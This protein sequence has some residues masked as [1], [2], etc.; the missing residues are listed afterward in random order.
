[1]STLHVSPGSATVSMGKFL[2]SLD[3]YIVYKNFSTLE[4][5]LYSR[6]CARPLPLRCLRIPAE[7]DNCRLFHRELVKIWQAKI[8]RHIISGKG[9]ALSKHKETGLSPRMGGGRITSCLE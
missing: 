7:K 4:H 3:F 8:E 6:C 9:V 5:Q 2:V 1:M